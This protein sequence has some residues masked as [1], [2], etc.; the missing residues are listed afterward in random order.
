MRGWASPAA[1]IGLTAQR[2]AE[3]SAPPRLSDPLSDGSLGSGLAMRLGGREVVV[4]PPFVFLQQ[5]K[6]LL[7]LDFA[8]AA[9]NCWVRKGGAF[10]GEIR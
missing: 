7:R 3:G 10:T 4:S 5:T 1:K 6:G 2:Y 9:Q 8:V